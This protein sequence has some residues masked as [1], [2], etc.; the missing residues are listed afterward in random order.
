MSGRLHVYFVLD[1]ATPLSQAMAD[2][3][4][5][6]HGFSC[7]ASQPINYYHATVQ[8]FSTYVQ[9]LTEHTLERLQVQLGNALSQLEPFTLTFQVPEARRYAVETIAQP[10]PSWD[11]VVG[12]V[13]EAARV[14]TGSDLPDPPFGPHMTLSYGVGDGDN[15][16]INRQITAA[17]F[18]IDQSIAHLDLV[19]VDQNRQSGVFEFE[20]LCRFALG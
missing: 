11:A 9:D 2:I 7:L 18:P 17:G 19:S 10:H 5:Q 3:S 15:E 13:R 14:T 8:Q 16:E 4:T 12:A 20:S 6:M 1:P